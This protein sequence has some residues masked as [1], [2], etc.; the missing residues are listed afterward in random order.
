MVELAPHPQRPALSSAE[1]ARASRSAVLSALTEGRPSTAADLV[2]RTGL[3]RPTVHNTL[4]GLVNQN[5]VVRCDQPR[6][7][8]GRPAPEFRLNVELGYVVGIDI[9]PSSLRVRVDDLRGPI[10]NHGRTDRPP[11]PGRGFADYILSVATPVGDRLNFIG[12]AVEDVLHRAGIPIQDVWASCIGTPGVV[13][14]GNISACTVI[15]DWQGD[16]LVRAARSW[17]SPGCVVAIENDANLAAVSE[18]AIGAA[19]GITGEVVSI[20]IG[21]RLGFGIL[22]EGRLYRGHHGRAGEAGTLPSSSWTTANN[23]LGEN[24]ATTVQIFKQALDG[25][26]AARSSVRSLA[27]MLAPPIAELAYTLDPALIVVGGAAT[28]AGEELIGP[29]NDALASYRVGTETVSVAPSPLG[30]HAVALG[31]GVHASRLA[32]P[33]LADRASP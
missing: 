6:R 4:N 7:T 10:P 26:H 25:D 31:A 24:A 18:G 2:G 3:S 12:S 23:W 27:E 17:F 20:Q 13:A 14:D 32:A 19:A 9:G 30:R 1:L 5:I 8:K 21:S 11:A 28:A 33:K 15:D 29:L 22:R 16:T